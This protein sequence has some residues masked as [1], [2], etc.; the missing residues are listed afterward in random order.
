MV[1]TPL[2]QSP[3]PFGKDSQPGSEESSDDPVSYKKTPP[4]PIRQNNSRPG[5]SDSGMYGSFV[6][7]PP[8]DPVKRPNFEL[9]EPAIPPE[10]A[11]AASDTIVETHSNSG[12]GPPRPSAFP[13]F[14]SMAVP[15]KTSRNKLS[16]WN[17]Y[18]IGE[19]GQQPSPGLLRRMFSVGTP[20][21]KADSNR[22]DVA[23][24]QV[25]TVRLRQKEFFSWMDSQLNKVEEFYK[26]KE[27][28]AG[29]R[30]KVLRDQLHEMRNRRIEEIAAARQAKANLH[31]GSRGNLHGSNGASQDNGNN[32][33]SPHETDRLKKILSPLEHM[34]EHAKIKALGPHVGANSKALEV[35]ATTPDIRSNEQRFR[36]SHVEEG[37]DYVRR[38][39]HV[40]SVPYRTAKRKLKIALKEYYRGLELLK[41]YALLNR[42]AFRKI[43]KKYDK[44]VN[45][46]PPLRYVSEK[47]N[48]SWFVKSE[49]IDNYM[50]DIEDLYARYFEKGSHKV[51]MDKLRSSMGR[52]TDKSWSAF[53]NG[54]LVGVGA[55]FL[56]QAIV[57]ATELLFDKD[58]TMSTNT[59]YLLQIYGG[60]FL[61]LY[62]FTWFCIDCRIWT[63]YKIN[64][65]F[66]FEFDLRH[67]IDWREMAQFPCFFILVMGLVAWFNF[68]QVGRNS[69]MYI[70][71]PIILVGVTLVVI[72]FP[73]PIMFH[74]SREWFA[75]SNVSQ[76]PDIRGL[77]HFTNGKLVAFTACWLIPRRVS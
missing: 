68:S 57:Y 37:R 10:P 75:Y 21:S 29:E 62:V 72:L 12:R 22:I 33:D 24:E 48:K 4:V 73:A 39:R 71:F 60:Y 15:Q 65:A 32:K 11:S 70:Y 66:V 16:T 27:D 19:N 5:P 59:S 6:P 18:K 51:A 49:V 43:N 36:G 53:T 76:N 8:K 30:L 56:I 35:M 45:A 64:Y 3:A 28:E 7:T 23:L 20:L 63:R 69:D 44:A 38:S 13:R 55:V 41:S 74:R 17:A 9:P 31:S 58:P 25:E 2:E 54:L 52:P 40:E 67:H 47:V 42:T 46:H 34:L 1:Y 77:Q 14:S 61:G 26:M 50:H